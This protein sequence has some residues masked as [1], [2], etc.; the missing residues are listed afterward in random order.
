MTILSKVTPQELQ[1]KLGWLTSHQAKKRGVP[2][3][4]VYRW[5]EILQKHDLAVKV[6]EVSGIQF[7]RGLWLLS[8]EAVE[9]L[10]GRKGQFGQEVDQEELERLIAD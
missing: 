9:F 7:G 2:D 8:P 3:Y 4:M 10:K 1:S 6:K 5:G